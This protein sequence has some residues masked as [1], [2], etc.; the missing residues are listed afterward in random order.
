MAREKADPTVEVLGRLGHQARLADPRLAGDG[1]DRPLAE[2][3]SV[4][5]VAQLA[6]L[7]RTADERRFGIGPAGARSAGH[8]ECGNGLDLALQLEIAQLLELEHVF[9]LACRRSRHNEVAER[10]QPRSH[11]DGVTE[12][13]VENVRRS[14]AG[15]DNDGAR[16]DRDARADVDAVRGAD[17]R[18]QAVD[19]LADRECGANGAQGV[20]LVGHWRPEECEDPVAR[21]LRD[22]AAEALHLHT[23]RPHDVVEQEL[24][25]L[26]P[27]PLGDRGR[28]GHVG[29]EH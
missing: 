15:R 22:R 8:A 12:G 27:E 26:R 13:V 29:D 21:Q 24:R 28:A 11:V 1:Y 7:S 19:C 4:E 25:P 16:V 10:L 3:K 18:A 14:V 17:L 23:H 6:E 2:E 9:D 5:H 20:V